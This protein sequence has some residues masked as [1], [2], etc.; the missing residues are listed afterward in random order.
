MG[1]CAMQLFEKWVEAD[2]EERR[3]QRRQEQLSQSNEE[4]KEARLSLREDIDRASQR[5]QR[6]LQQ[7]PLWR[8][9]RFIIDL[10]VLFN[11]RRG[12]V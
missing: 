2:R 5:K 6:L 7:S 1:L 10:L 12:D 9:G 8:L 4:T 3:L 11:L